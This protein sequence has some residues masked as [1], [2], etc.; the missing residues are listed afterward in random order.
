MAGVPRIFQGTLT[1]RGRLRAEDYVARRLYPSPVSLFRACA[2]PYASLLPRVTN[3]SIPEIVAGTTNCPN[4]ACINYALPAPVHL[5][6]LAIGCWRETAEAN[7][8]GAT[9]AHAVARGITWIS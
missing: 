1:A 9:G 8:I 2:G 7:L 5:R 3:C 4:V 6:L